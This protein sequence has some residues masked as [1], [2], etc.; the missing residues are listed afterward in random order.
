MAFLT[1]QINIL[2]ILMPSNQSIML[3]IITYFS[4]YLLNDVANDI[5][6]F[7]WLKMISL[8]HLK[9]NLSIIKLYDF[10]H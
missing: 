2:F 3:N 8:V 7:H 6:I 5:L 10:N 4:N 1:F 9:I